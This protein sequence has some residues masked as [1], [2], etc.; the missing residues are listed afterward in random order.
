[1]SVAGRA[2]ILYGT[3]PKCLANTQIVQKY[4][5]IFSLFVVMSGKMYI[6]GS[7]SD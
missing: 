7:I 1:M 5:F 3:C 6:F 4:L 2:G